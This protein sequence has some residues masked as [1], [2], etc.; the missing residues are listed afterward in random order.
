M[1]NVGSIDR[2]V[3]IIVAL[4]LAFAAA[5]GMVTG[6][7]AIAAWVV[8]AVFAVT[9]VIGFCPAYRLIGVDTCRRP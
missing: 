6:G 5:T 2:L 1:K 4:A 9:S 7:W 3:R 8:A